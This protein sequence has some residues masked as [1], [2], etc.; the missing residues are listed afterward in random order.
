ML[1]FFA[2][3]HDKENI[4]PLGEYKLKNIYKDLSIGEIPFSVTISLDK[5]SE[6]FTPQPDITCEEADS[7]IS[8]EYEFVTP[9]VTFK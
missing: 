4:L 8:T 9:E 2:K 5:V 1:F 7:V 6:D 3:C